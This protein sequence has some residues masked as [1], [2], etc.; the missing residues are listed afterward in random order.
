MAISVLTQGVKRYYA[1][2]NAALMGK[3]LDAVLFPIQDNSPNAT[4]RLDTYTGNGFALSSIRQGEP[5]V[6]VAYAPGTGYEHEVLAYKRKTPIGEQLR[7]AVVAGIEATSPQSAHVRRAIEQIIGGPKGFI[8][9][10]KMM[11]NKM[12]LDVYLTGKMVNYDA[13]GNSDEVD[14][15]RAGALTKT[16]DFSTSGNSFDDAIR[17]QYNAMRAYGVPQSKLAVILGADWLHE[18]EV[19]GT[20]I[21]K[22][23]ATAFGSYVVENMV[24][25]Q[26]QG[27]EGL[28]VI[29][30]YNVDGM[31]A[32]IWILAY[33]PDWQYRATDGGSLEEYMP[34]TKM[35]MFD[36]GGMA[37]RCNRGID[38]LDPRGN[39]VRRVGDLVI[40]SFKQ[41]DPPVEWIR[42]TCRPFY[43]R[44][45]INHTSVCTGSNFTA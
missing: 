16:Y 43:I 19:D 1:D 8:A 32:P 27:T 3:Q 34:S 14:F 23:K 26:F 42:A 35:V 21:E 20:V 2:Q 38:V 12:A 41:D 36:I 45:N 33:S 29:G 7:D 30:R 31:V 18:F 4:V 22:R 10:N 15:G 6:A 17:D 25:S 44:G 24:P 13:A 11:R 9:A 37:W 5:S 40:D 39:I 28:Q